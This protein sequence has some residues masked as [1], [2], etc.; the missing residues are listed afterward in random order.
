MIT[1]KV[2]MKQLGNYTMLKKLT[3]FFLLLLFATIF[4]TCKKYPDGGSIPILGKVENTIKGTWGVESLTV[5][6]VDSTDHFK[7]NPNYCEYPITFW[8]YGKWE[9]AITGSECGKFYNRYNWSTKDHNKLLTIDFQ[10]GD[11]LNEKLPPLIFNADI[12]I[13]WTIQ[14]L[15]KNQMWLKTNINSKDYFIKLNKKQ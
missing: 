8:Y 13:I 9:Q 3:Y 7:A 6:G 14:R 10:K 5:D 12:Y 1:D 15:K 4:E 2:Q 11:S